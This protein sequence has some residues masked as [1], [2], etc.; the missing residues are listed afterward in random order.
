ME[1][2]VTGI[3]SDAARSRI[4]S[5]V[6]RVENQAPRPARGGQIG[7][8]EYWEAAFLV[9]KAPAN[10]SKG[11]FGKINIYRGL[12]K[13]G[14]TYTTGDDVMAFARGVSIT[15]ARWVYVI[16]V[17]GADSNGYGGYEVVPCEC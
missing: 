5:A 15:A 9:G 10:I 7:A 6:R 16:R 1:Q 12:N 4:N 8:T 14:E 11:Q 3:Y 13:G 17:N 2:T